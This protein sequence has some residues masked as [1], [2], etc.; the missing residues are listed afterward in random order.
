M[1]LFKYVTICSVYKDGEPKKKKKFFYFFS[2][3]EFFVWNWEKNI[4]FGIGN[5]AELRPQNR[6]IESPA[7]KLY[8]KASK[9]RECVL[10]NTQL[11]FIS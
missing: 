1:K 8:G 7:C 2:N 9:P 6:V 5:G 10:D 4:L 11:R 3:W